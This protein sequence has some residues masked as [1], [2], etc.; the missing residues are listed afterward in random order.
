[1]TLDFALGTVGIG[2]IDLLKIDVEGAEIA[3]LKGAGNSL[4]NTLAIEL[5]VWFN[6]VQQGAPS[7]AEIDPLLRVAGFQLF[8]LAKSNFFQRDA[9]WPKGQLVAG[10][11]LYF[12]VGLDLTPERLERYVGVV[13]A[14]GFYD[15]AIDLIQR[16]HCLSDAQ[17]QARIAQVQRAGKRFRFRGQ[18]RLA[19]YFGRLARRLATVERDH[20][21]NDV[22]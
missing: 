11:A 8:D 7:F 9:R 18:D 10:D 17:K 2:E 21:G 14:Y 13:L 12:K 1:M 6:P 16:A 19:S 3:I 15:Y 5:E 22:R 20:L 4:R